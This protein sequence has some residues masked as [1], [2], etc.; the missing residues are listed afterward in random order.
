MR[1]PP[2]QVDRLRHDRAERQRWL[3]DSGMRRNTPREFHDNVLTMYG[4]TGPSKTRMGV[5][6]D[7]F[8]YMLLVDPDGHVR[9]QHAGRFD[10]ARF[11]DLWALA[12][13]LA[14]H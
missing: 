11:E 13:E 2:P 14:G 7:N 6:D 9:W 10:Q 12:D 1:S 5:T 4:G 8:A 3:I